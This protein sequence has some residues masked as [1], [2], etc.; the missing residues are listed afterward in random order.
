MAFRESR[1]QCVTVSLH[2]RR[3]LQTSP[4][5]SP[6]SPP[7]QA[8][9]LQ[10]FS[11]LAAKYTLQDGIESDD[12]CFAGTD[13]SDNRDQ[14]DTDTSDNDTDSCD[15]NVTILSIELWT[16]CIINCRIKHITFSS[17]VV[18][19]QLHGIMLGRNWHI[20]IGAISFHPRNDKTRFWKFFRYVS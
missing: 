15:S 9:C 18:V 8:W 16:C 7:P 5:P 17:I 10:R 11:A 1:F 3:S 6:P 4:L 13:Q 14:S 2:L 20:K 19:I 12:D